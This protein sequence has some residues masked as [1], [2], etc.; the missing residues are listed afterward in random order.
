MYFIVIWES[1]ETE[2][3]NFLDH[4]KKEGF[5]FNASELEAQMIG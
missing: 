5:Q 4:K 1:F 2:E 3:G